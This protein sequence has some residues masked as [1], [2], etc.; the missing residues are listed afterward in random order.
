MDRIVGARAAQG[1]RGRAGLADAFR[2]A[3]AAHPSGVAVITAA[4]P[5]G[6]VG[7]TAS[8]VISVAVAPP[9]LAFSLSSTRGSVGALLASSQLAVHLLTSADEELAR[10]FSAAGIDRFGPDLDWHPAPTGEP[11]LETRGTILRCRV[12]T[13][14]PV[15]GSSLVAAQVTDILVVGTTAVP[16]EGP[17]VHFRRGYH[18]VAADG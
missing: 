4:G 1:A 10:R 18:R 12:L 5:R 9:V 14:T 2:E 6:P 3:F 13:R 15:A 17:L 11:L 16:S 7:L 8:S